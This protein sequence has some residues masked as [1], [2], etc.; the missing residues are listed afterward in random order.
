MKI[1]SKFKL[2]RSKISVGA[3]QH[4]F[5][6]T[7]IS[8]VLT[9]LLI[10]MLAALIVRAIDSEAYPSYVVALVNVLQWMIIPGS[11]LLPESLWIRVLAVLVFVVGLVLFSGTIIA[12]TTTHLKRYI[13]HKADAKGKLSLSGHLIVL[14]YNDKFSSI[15]QAMSYHDISDTVLI[16]SHMDK[17]AINDVVQHESMIATEKP[18]NQVNLIVRQGN[19]HSLSELDDICLN[20]AK[21]VLILHDYVMKDDET[22]MDCINILISVGTQSMLEDSHI[23]VESTTRELYH[24]TESIISS[25][26]SLQS[27]V[28]LPYSTDLIISKFLAMSI[29]QPSVVDVIYRLLSFQDE[30]IYVIDSTLSISQY[31]ELY[32][33]SLP[34]YS[35]DG[36][37]YVLAKSREDIL[38]SNCVDVPPIVELFVSTPVQKKLLC[39]IYGNNDKLDD[40]VYYLKNA[41]CKQNAEFRIQNSELRGSV[42]YKLFDKNQLTEF[43]QNLKDTQPDIVVLL[44][45]DKNDDNVMLALIELQRVYGTEPPFKIL[46]QIKDPNKQSN[47]SEFGIQSIIV[48]SKVVSLFAM[49][50]L[51]NRDM[52]GFYDMLLSAGLGNLDIAINPLYQILDI[53]INMSGFVSCNQFVRSIHASSGGGMLP[54]GVINGES[55]EFFFNNSDNIHEMLMGDEMELIYLKYRI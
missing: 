52:Y 17:N 20:Q 21:A 13:V 26:P 5:V 40:V 54:I 25:L 42:E 24:T 47:I 11:V 33:D 3:S 38:K 43:F 55:I 23:L 49:Q 46:V 7:I 6:F 8:L 53:N 32:T 1:L 30:S 45:S 12:L 41:E 2:M 16:L 44:S 37:M 48:S 50:S 35:N 36:K 51:L 19:P 39:Y 18:L 29:V 15:I 31:L 9:N 34:L 27:R 14:N 4:P 10:L 28:V 22:S